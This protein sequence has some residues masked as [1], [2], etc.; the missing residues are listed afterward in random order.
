MVVELLDLLGDDLHEGVRDLVQ[1]VAKDGGTAAAKL[2]QFL[3]GQ[4]TAPARVDQH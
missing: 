4:L 3:F 1:G 2:I